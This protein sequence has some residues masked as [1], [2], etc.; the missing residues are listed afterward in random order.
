[1]VSAL[2]HRKPFGFPVCDDVLPVLRFATCW[3]W[4]LITPRAG[5][6]YHGGVDG[7]SLGVWGKGRG[8]SGGCPIRVLGLSRD[9]PVTVP[10]ALT[11]LPITLYGALFS[12]HRIASLK[13]A[14]SYQD[15]VKWR[16]SISHRLHEVGCVHPT[17]S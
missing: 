15:R 11:A 14:H 6:T 7:V 3:T 2:V 4:K 10:L 8:R 1:L 9:C 16:S 12:Y 17:T 13:G 5:Y